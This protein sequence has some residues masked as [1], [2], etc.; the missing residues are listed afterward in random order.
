MRNAIVFVLM[1]VVVGMSIGD[2]LGVSAKAQTRQTR[3]EDSQLTWPPSPEGMVQL[4]GEHAFIN[5]DTLPVHRV[6]YGRWLVVTMFY[7]ANYQLVED[8]GG[9]E[10]LK[11]SNRTTTYELSKHTA[12][13]A[14]RPGSQVL[15]RHTTTSSVE[16]WS[17]AGY[18]TTSERPAREWPPLPQDLVNVVGQVL[19]PVGEVVPLYTVPSDRWLVMMDLKLRD[20]GFWLY[21]TIG[22][23]SRVLSSGPGANNDRIV[24]TTFAPGSQVAIERR[25]GNPGTVNWEFHGY[26]VRR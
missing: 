10:T 6:P 9:I 17:L 22:G 14:F 16:Y 12:G 5:S 2:R 7:G 20:G 18:L 1:A 3:W 21:E 15:L 13:I 24:G 26:F 23:T 4:G 25:L 11:Y 19:A 8:L